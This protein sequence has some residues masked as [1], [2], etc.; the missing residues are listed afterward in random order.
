M[1]DRKPDCFGEFRV[2]PKDWISKLTNAVATWEISH[3]WT[4]SIE[5]E[6]DL[7]EK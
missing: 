7:F 2:D 5:A 6:C 1:D 4:I 3:L